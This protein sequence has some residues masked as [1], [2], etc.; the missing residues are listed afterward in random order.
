MRYNNKNYDPLFRYDSNKETKHLFYVILLCSHV[1]VYLRLQAARVTHAC[2]ALK[3]T[4]PEIRARPMQYRQTPQLDL[5]SLVNFI[6]SLELR[7]RS[8]MHATC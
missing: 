7:V 6:S 8:R 3:D 1:H 2:D 4:G 5:D